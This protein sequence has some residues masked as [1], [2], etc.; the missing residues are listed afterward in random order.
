MANFQFFMDNFDKLMEDAKVQVESL[1]NDLKD[2]PMTV[3]TLLIK[4]QEQLHEAKEQAELLSAKVISGEVF[5]KDYK[6]ELQKVVSELETA[7]HQIFASIK[8]AIENAK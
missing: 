6:P 1:S 4:G 8:T 7:T 5:K 3:E 2:L